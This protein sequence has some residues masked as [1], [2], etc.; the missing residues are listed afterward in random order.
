MF[1]ERNFFWD[2]IKPK[3]NPNPQAPKKLGPPTRLGPTNPIYSSMVVSHPFILISSA[4]V[5]V[6]IGTFLSR[7]PQNI[8]IGGKPS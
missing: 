7:N 3:P 1:Y 2:Q 6:K 5:E 8:K 4:F